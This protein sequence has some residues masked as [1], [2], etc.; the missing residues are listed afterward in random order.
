MARTGPPDAARFRPGHRR[1]LLQPLWLFWTT[2]DGKARS[3][4]PD[5]FARKADG[6]ALVLD[7]RP[8]NR[9]KPRDQV[10]FDAA[11]MACEL[12]GWRYEVVGP[13]PEV[14]VRNVRWLACYSHP[15]HHLLDTAAA[16]RA[17]FPNLPA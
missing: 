5:Y 4:A 8:L 3:H 9:I 2:D 1:D 7:C 16:L 14:L 11:R 17:V 6:T 15:R 12:L 10:A 13:A